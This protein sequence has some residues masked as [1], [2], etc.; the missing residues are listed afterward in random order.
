MGKENWPDL[1]ALTSMFLV[2][3]PGIEPGTEMALTCKNTENRYAK[4]RETTRR[5]LR[6]REKC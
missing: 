6:R 4:A 1:V 3:L 2:E 5:D